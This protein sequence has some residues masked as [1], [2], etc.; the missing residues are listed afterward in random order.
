MSIYDINNLNEISKDIYQEIKHN[1]KII[2]ENLE[3]DFG[4]TITNYLNKVEENKELLL[5]INANYNNFKDFPSPHHPARPGPLG[6]E[7]E[8]K[9]R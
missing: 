4:N 7:G 9:G 5:F 3:L 8:G 6:E 1:V 2:N